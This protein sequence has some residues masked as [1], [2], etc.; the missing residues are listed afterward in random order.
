MQTLIDAVTSQIN[1]ASVDARV[2][3]DAIRRLFS[4][5]WLACRTVWDSIGQPVFD[6][7]GSKLDELESLFF[8]LHEVVQPIVE[9]VLTA[10]TNGFDNLFVVW[11]DVVMPALSLLID[12]FFELGNTILTY[13]AP[14]VQLICEKFLELQEA[15]IAAVQNYIVPVI[16]Q[17]IT[18]IQTLWAENQDKIQA[19]GALF[20]AGFQAIANLVSWF[21]GVFKGYIQP[22]LAWLSS[23]VSANMDNIK[24]IF[25]AAFDVIGGI[26]S[27]FTALFRGDWSGMWD[28]IKQIASSAVEL[29][30]NI[31]STMQSVLSSIV[32]GIRS[33]ITGIWEGIKS[34][35][36][37]IWEGIKSAASSIW[38][39]IKT[40][41]MTPV[42][43]V[44]T[45]VSTA[46]NNIKTTAT[47][48]WE[49]IKN[50]I[51][52]PI[53][54]AKEK[55][56]SV[57]D[58]I[59]GFFNFSFSW[60]KIKMPHFGITPSGWKIGD[61]LKGS[62][63]KLGIEWYAKGGVLQE[64][65]V[66]DYDNGVA[67]VGGEAGPEAVAPIETLQKYVGEAVAGQNHEL[68]D[69]LQQLLTAVQAL[70]AGLLDKLLE[71]LSVMRF[72]IRQREFGR[73][74]REVL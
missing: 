65:T 71:A 36:S 43:V 61:L 62:I 74:V 47:N 53:E 22:F 56:R 42:E 13:I 39:N 35:L 48:I 33:K 51:A 18:M 23:I 30:K 52:T 6:L 66:F 70:D 20:Q 11:N 24:S 8:S 15:V 44:K 55:V 25:Q 64:P 19:I 49:G 37:G 72:E 41:V 10:L 38:N 54:A 34:T 12:I 3:F 1:V 68:L 17:F 21:V 59:K 7:L 31:F 50:A 5:L 63:P 4:N 60:P 27:F 29:V 2:I 14:P 57:I 69:V 16:Q 32:E 67:K 73:L 28:A 46:F 58:A 9:T 40:A 26:V 45:S